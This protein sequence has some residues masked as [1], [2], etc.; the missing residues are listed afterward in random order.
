VPGQLLSWLDEAGAWRLMSPAGHVVLNGQVFTRIERYNSGTVQ[1]FD[2]PDRVGVLSSSLRWLVP[3]QPQRFYYAAA[4][5]PR[6]TDPYWRTAQFVARNGQH[7][8]LSLRDGRSITTVAYD[9]IL[10]SFSDSYFGAVR[11]GRHYVLNQQGLEIAE[12]DIALGYGDNY[13]WRPDGWYVDNRC[14]LPASWVPVVRSGREVALVDSLGRP[15]T[16]WWPYQAERN[17]Y[18]CPPP[19]Y[20]CNGLSMVTQCGASLTMGVGDQSGRLIIPFSNHRIWYRN[21]LYLALG[22]DIQLFTD[23]GKALFFPARASAKLLPHGWAASTMALVNR[24]G[25]LYSVPPGQLWEKQLFLGEKYE[26]YPFEFGFWKTQWGYVTEAG[27]LL[28][29]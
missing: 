4:F 13:R 9:T 11:K 22:K 12:S 28:W 29:E 23:T 24:D 26:S 1:V 14:V 15:Q 8:V 20:T 10:T 18:G 16:A 6:T 2:G 25:R 19:I 17:G 7:H 21:G 3:L 27:R 5:D